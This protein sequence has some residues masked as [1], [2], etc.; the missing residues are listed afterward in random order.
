MKIT[1]FKLVIVAINKAILPR[2]NANPPT[3]AMMWKPNGIMITPKAAIPNTIA[4]IILRRR[5]LLASP[6][7]EDND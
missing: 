3:F 1:L 6:C 7:S 4:G 5:R 2:S